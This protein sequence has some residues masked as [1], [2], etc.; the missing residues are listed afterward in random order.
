MVS[1][2]VSILFQRT[3]LWSLNDD[4]LLVTDFDD[5]TDVT[6][7]GDFDDGSPGP[8]TYNDF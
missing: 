1:A 3:L 7:D 5:G 6:G 4:F 8:V 2:T